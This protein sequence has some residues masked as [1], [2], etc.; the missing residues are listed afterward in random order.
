MKNNLSVVL[1]MSIFIALVL[2]CGMSDKFQKAVE[3][4]KPAKSDVPNSVDK[5]LTDK[6]IDTVADGETTGVAECDEVIAMIDAA[7]SD[8][9]DGWMAKATKG[10]V[11]GLLKKGIKEEMANNKNDPK[12]LA[13]ECTDMKKQVVKALEEANNSTKE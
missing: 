5:S 8:P 9:N 13:Q 1:V 7:I 6:T 4:D 12:K 2:G 11:F 10:Y 3:G